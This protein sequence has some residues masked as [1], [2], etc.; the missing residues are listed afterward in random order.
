LLYTNR[1]RGCGLAELAGFPQGLCHPFSPPLIYMSFA[2][3]YPGSPYYLPTSSTIDI[4]RV[5]VGSQPSNIFYK[6]NIPLPTGLTIDPSNG[7]I[8]G[9]TLC[10]KNKFHL[11]LEFIFLF[12]IFYFFL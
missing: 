12:F 11:P 8:K 3:S 6:I 4:S 1:I 9:F 7:T 2:F 5:V 10:K